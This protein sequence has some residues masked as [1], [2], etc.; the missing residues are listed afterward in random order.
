M[1][2]LD[3]DYKTLPCGIIKK[4]AENELSNIDK[5][6]LTVYP[7]PAGE[8]V[9]IQY[10]NNYQFG[11]LKV[12]NNTGQL[13]M[14]QKLFDPSSIEVELN[15]LENGIYRIIVINENGESLNNNLLITR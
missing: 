15:Y 3:V 5:N 8:W 14:N 7:N 4:E 13:I 1:K 2:Y 11:N 12:Y 10:P 9:T 6:E